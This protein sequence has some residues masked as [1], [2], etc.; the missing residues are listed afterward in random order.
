[1][2]IIII[3]IKHVHKQTAGQQ[4]VLFSHPLRLNCFY[5]RYANRTLQV[6]VISSLLHTTCFYAV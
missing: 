4:F 3:V 1:M 6:T 2:K 5:R